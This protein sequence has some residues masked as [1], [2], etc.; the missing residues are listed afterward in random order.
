MELNAEVNIVLKTLVFLLILSKSILFFP[1]DLR[2]LI[3]WV[4]L[5]P[6]KKCYVS[7][8]NFFN[9]WIFFFFGGGGGGSI[10]ASKA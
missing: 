6:N 9:A 4:Y 7:P 8:F 2:T 3:K 5:E 1:L 10:A